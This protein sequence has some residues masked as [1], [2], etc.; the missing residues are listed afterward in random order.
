MCRERL[1]ADPRIRERLEG[2]A[3]E[4]G[5]PFEHLAAAVDRPA[6]PGMD[7]EQWADAMATTARELAPLPREVLTQ[8]ARMAAAA[9]EGVDAA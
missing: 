7:P 4:T 2:F 8:V 1:S 3:V 5:I 9:R 6:L